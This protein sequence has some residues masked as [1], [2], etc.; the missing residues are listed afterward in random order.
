[1][2]DSHTA[3]IGSIPEYYDQ[4]FGPII[5]EEYAQDMARRVSV[6]DGGTVLEIAAG[7]GIVTRHLRN[8]MP[9]AVK[10]IATDLNESMLE[11]AQRKFNGHENIKFEPANAVNLSYPPGYFDAVVSQFSLMF[12]LDKQIAINETARVLK[13]GGTFIF[14]IWDSF[15]HNHLLQTVNES[16]IQL[17]D[18]P[19]NFFDVPY[20]Y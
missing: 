18:N 8:A 14:S 9:Q 16:L 10:V 17:C 15:K 3:F 6:P 20:C 2:V 5:F 13:P 19:P 1:M 4:Y 11:Y 7:T 12:F